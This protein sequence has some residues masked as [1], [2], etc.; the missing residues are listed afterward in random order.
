[1]SRLP[2]HPPRVAALLLRI[3]LPAGQVRDS[4]LGDFWEEHGR[5]AARGGFLKARL[6]YWRQALG[7]GRTPLA[8]N[9]AVAAFE[10][11]LGVGMNVAPQ[12]DDVRAE[13]LGGFEKVRC[14]FAH[15]ATLV[16]PRLV[17][18]KGSCPEARIV[19]L[20]ARSRIHRPYC[21]CCCCSWRR[22]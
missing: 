11:D 16:G 17:S 18:P 14:V 4:S 20:S 6:W 3:T 21:C 2:K 5:L 8:H 10:A 12:R 13:R 22:T 15:A 19:L 9:F 1:M 7:R